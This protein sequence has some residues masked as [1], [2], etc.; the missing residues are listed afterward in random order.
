MFYR[1]NFCC[2][3]GEKIERLDWKPWTSRRFCDLCGTDHQVRE[4]APKAVFVVGLLGVL[5]GIGSYLPASGSKQDPE[6][7]RLPVTRKASREPGP[8]NQQ[9]TATVPLKSQ[10][11][12]AE[13][14]VTG[15]DN[16]GTAGESVTERKTARNEP[17]YFC[18]ARTKK[19]TPCSRRVKSKGR[20][21]QHAGLP[22]ILDDEDLRADTER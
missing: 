18:G 2:E 12:A 8:A 17:V 14:S 6:P 13:L 21:W 20:C 19:G 15:Q 22:A 3:C 7:Q 1:P 16:S 10:S 11:G 5:F 9:A 4:I